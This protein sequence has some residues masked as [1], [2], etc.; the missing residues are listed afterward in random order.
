MAESVVNELLKKTPAFG[1]DSREACPEVDK[2]A[3][4][5]S[6]MAVM[7]RM[8][9]EKK[10]SSYLTR[11]GIENYIPI[12]EQYHRWSD[13][14][15]KVDH[16]VVSM[17]AFVHISPSEK[18]TVLSVPAVCRFITPPGT[19]RPAVIPDVQMERFRF[20]L[21]YSDE[22]VHLSS[23]HFGVGETV[24]V[25]KGPLAG[26]EG[27]LVMVGDSPNV[28]VHIDNI[29]YAYISMPI[30]YIDKMEKIQ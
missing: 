19:N 3:N 28:A 9:H 20:M 18:I 17:M 27:S 21:D 11:C 26:M 4:K 6:W 25:I 8:N 2:N 14:V 15:K 7:V 29:G 1:T 30:G 12:Q 16:L 23:G 10:V 24:R 5:K 22:C 13:R